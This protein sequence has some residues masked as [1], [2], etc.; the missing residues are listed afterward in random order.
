M[1]LCVYVC[2][3]GIKF[4][5]IKE[6]FHNN[7]IS[8]IEFNVEMF[9]KIHLFYLFIDIDLFYVIIILL[10]VYRLQMNKEMKWNVM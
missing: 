10:S 9:N 7:P 1:C 6:Y 2:K 3:I 5:S 8:F 4:Y